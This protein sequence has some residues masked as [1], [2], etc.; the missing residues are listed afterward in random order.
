MLF[1]WQERGRLALVAGVLLFLVLFVPGLVWHY[2]RY[3]RPSL[4]RLV[5]LA[6]V[7]LYATAIV[8][9]TTMPLPDSTGQWCQS[10]SAD[11]NTSPFQFLEEIL[12]AIDAVGRR[13]ALRSEAFLQA[14]FNVAFFVPFG[15][16]GIR[17]L[18]WRAPVVVGMAVVVSAG[19]EAVQ[20]VGIPVLY[21]CAYRVADV[22]DVILNA[23]GALLGVVLA[24]VLLWWMPS[25]RALS[26]ERLQPRPVT[27]VRRWTGM[28]VDVLLAAVVGTG[29]TWVVR[30][31]RILAG[32]SHP[33]VLDTVEFAAGLLVALVCVFLGP[34]WSG[35]GATIGQ[36]SVW[37]APTW[38]PTPSVGALPRGTSSRVE[39][40]RVDEGGRALGWDGRRW[41]RLVCAG[42]LPA[43][44]AGCLLVAE[45]STANS[46]PVVAGAALGLAGVL[47]VAEVTLVPVG[48]GC[49]GLS[50]I[51]ARAW[52]RDSREDRRLQGRWAPP[53]AWRT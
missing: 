11:R 45:T 4:A 49:R 21:P 13:A 44:V 41:Q 6:M 28:V 47:A 35:R 17:Y 14:V 46:R 37:L 38:G 29:T 7:C 22:D 31:V 19:V 15:V 23:F 27:V 24:P 34:A 52:F 42:A 9:Y 20:A 5:G 30:A 16:I 51:I 12:A 18:R 48:S 25:A 50:G 26:R 8:A 1:H 36:A 3:G 33:A 2:R 10:H 43:V 32:A 39:G 53:D 40:S